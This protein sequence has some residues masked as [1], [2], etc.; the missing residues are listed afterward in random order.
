MAAQPAT[1]SSQIAANAPHDYFP[2]TCVY[3]FRYLEASLND[4][5]IQTLTEV[6][7]IDERHGC[8]LQL[9]CQRDYQL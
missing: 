7:F 8:Q 4:E 1:F 5:R 6:W 3:E 9:L 2:R